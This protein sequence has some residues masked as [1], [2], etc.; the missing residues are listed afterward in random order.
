MQSLLSNRRKNVT[1]RKSVSTAK[2]GKRGGQ[3]SPTKAVNPIANRINPNSNR[4]TPKVRLKPNFKAHRQVDILNKLSNDF[5]NNEQA[6]R[7]I[8]ER[9]PDFN[10]RLV[11]D[12]GNFVYQYHL[13]E[14]KEIL[15]KEAVSQLREILQKQNPY[16]DFDNFRWEMVDNNIPLKLV[17]N[18]INK[19]K[20]RR[21]EKLGIVVSEETAGD[22]KSKLYINSINAIIGI[23]MT[24]PRMHRDNEMPIIAKIEE[25]NE[26]FYLDFDTHII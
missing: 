10:I 22:K 14:D 26:N 2:Q 20:K 11:S 12:Q 3:L 13:H 25:N 7:H 9:N 1:S 17:S 5:S 23:D 21:N 6:L 16:L 19:R 18:D 8:R 15:V 4:R 24:I